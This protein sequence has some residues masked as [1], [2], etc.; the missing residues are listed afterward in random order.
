MNN[1]PELTAL[2]AHAFDDER[3]LV[4]ELLG[5]AT[6]FQEKAH[7]IFDRARKYVEDIRE[8]SDGLSIETFLNEYSLDSHEGV[9]IMCL[10]EALLRV[11]DA[12]SADEL[13]RDKLEKGDWK[14]HISKDSGLLLNSSTYGLMLSGR[15]LS[16]SKDSGAL[17]SALSRITGRMGEP[18]VREALKKG[19]QILGQKFVLGT[20]IKKALDK[21]A[22]IGK[23]GYIFSFDMLGEGARTQEQA[24]KFFNSY[25]QGI[26]AV[27][28]L[29]EN[30]STPLF[31]RNNVSVKLSALHPRY[32]LAKSE[33][34]MNE[35]LPRLKKIALEARD[36]NIWM[37]IDAEESYRLELSLMVFE[38]LLKDDYFKDYNGL[39]FVVQAYGKRALP[40]I[41]YLRT[42]AEKY[43]KKIPVRLVKGAYWDSEIKNA[44]IAGL[45]NYPVFTRKSH[46]DLSY[47]VCA[48][49]MLE[50]L[51]Y[52]YPQFATHNA[53]TVA[54]IL[55]IAGDAPQGSYEFQR[56][57]GMG[58]AFYDNLVKQLPVRIYAPVGTYAE[59]LPYLIR[60]IVEN[61]SNNSFV[62]L[63][64]DEDEPIGQLLTS[65]IEKIIKQAYTSKKVPLPNEIYLPERENSEGYDLGNLDHFKELEHILEK[66]I[67]A[68]VKALSIIGSK[69]K[70]AGEANIDEAVKT[71]KGAWKEWNAKGFDARADVLDEYADLLWENSDELLNILVYEAKKKPKDAI[72]EL[73]EAID[74][75]R[76]YA[77]QARKLEATKLPGYTGE[78]SVLHHRGKGVVACISPWNFPLAI[79]LGQVSAALV[80]G[81]CVIAKPAEQTPKIALRAVQLAYE[82]G[83]PKEVLQLVVGSGA[84]FGKALTEHNDIAG[85]AFTGSTETAWKINRSLAARNT[86][87]ATLIAETGGQNVMIVD[88]TALLEKAVDDAVESA[89]GSAGQRCSAARVVYVQEDVADEFIN[90]LKGAIEELKLGNAHELATDV[91]AV[92]DAAAQKNLQAHIDDMKAHA[93][94]IAAAKAPDAEGSF[95]LPHAFE[96]ASI[97][98]LRKE[99]FG[100]I[101]H[102]IR[103]KRA[104]IDKVI[105]EINATGYALTFGIQSR[106]YSFIDHVIS[107]INAGNI[108]VN[109]SIIGAVVGTHPFGGNGLSGTGPK[110][111]GPNYLQRFLN[112]VVI[113]DNTA[114]IGG[115]LELIT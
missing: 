65:P 78:R 51:K 97:N 59:L 89:F 13:I 82:A 77:A 44:Q 24:E 83:I 33:R 88:S 39:G 36:N 85:V 90:I 108:Y 5:K 71:A 8:N 87:I 91:P 61:G 20:D 100:P 99:N 113:T 72:A 28:K 54:S 104:D 107:G 111:G 80:A 102:V 60:R 56:L 95:V 19:M 63:V 112:E 105:D 27:G 15:I 7:D 40:V 73:R 84:V 94:L 74:F 86:S 9:A 67:S 62:S 109:R 93:K 68:D 58:D 17:H 21:A 1:L 75:L 31:Q 14:K 103:F 11:P 92:I 22:K 37:A 42:L 79:F 50:N 3:R 70:Q 6:I 57:Y 49:E 52:F 32:E 18:L 64:V 26:R 38:E 81:N 114:A 4:K 29:H 115:D 98:I 106:V 53:L 10:A 12:E 43:G 47:L 35:L 16:L 45:E 25:K 34:V 41:K 101:L 55:E 46:T 2:A 48:K 69:E 110:A 30:D 76:Y 66:D 96:I 23:Q